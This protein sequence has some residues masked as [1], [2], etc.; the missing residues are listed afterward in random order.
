MFGWRPSAEDGHHP[1]YSVVRRPVPHLTG[2]KSATL[3]GQLGLLIEKLIP[4]EKFL[5]KWLMI[6]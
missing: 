3:A 2:D 4:I 1:N 6:F 5:A